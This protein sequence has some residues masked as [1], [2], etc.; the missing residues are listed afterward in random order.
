M[1]RR[2]RV[3]RIGEACLGSLISVFIAAIA[4]VPNVPQ[5]AVSAGFLLVVAVSVFVLMYRRV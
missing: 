3:G 2:V 1:G 4:I 5:V